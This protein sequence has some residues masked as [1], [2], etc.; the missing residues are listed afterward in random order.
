MDQVSKNSK[1]GHMKFTSEHVY[2]RSPRRT[3]EIKKVKGERNRM[4]E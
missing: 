4:E 3:N 2:Y 1:R